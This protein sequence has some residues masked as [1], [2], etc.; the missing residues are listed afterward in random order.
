[1]LLK[2]PGKETYHQ[3]YFLLKFWEIGLVFNTLLTF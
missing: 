3:H 2:F 1:M